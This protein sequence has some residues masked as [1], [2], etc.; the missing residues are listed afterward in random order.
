M[1]FGQMHERNSAIIT[2]AKRFDRTPGSVA[3]K[4]C[5]LASLD[6]V[7][8]LRGIKG[9][10]GASKLDEIVWTEFHAYL[11]ETVPTSEE[12]LRSLVKASEDAEVQIQSKKRN[13]PRQSTTNRFHG[14]YHE[15]QSV[16][17]AKLL[18]QRSDEQLRQSL[19]R[20]TNWLTRTS[21]RLS[22]P[23]MGSVCFGATECK[24]RHMPLP[25]T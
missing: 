1:R 20:V 11:D 18:P 22:D 3:M 21:Y 9:L 16:T 6:P 19:R 5:N 25:A 8:K 13:L 14:C 23:S 24:K 12:A 17:R 7:L 4:L 2:L 15:R 10:S